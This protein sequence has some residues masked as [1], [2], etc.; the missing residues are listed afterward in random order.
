MYVYCIRYAALAQPLVK[1]TGRL[2]G[3]GSLSVRGMDRCVQSYVKYRRSSYIN[4][5]I[6]FQFLMVEIH[7]GST[8][9]FTKPFI[10]KQIK[11]NISKQTEVLG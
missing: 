1:L 10:S 3:R 11:A 5:V 4:R 6:L 2:Y 9:Y 8:I 7:G